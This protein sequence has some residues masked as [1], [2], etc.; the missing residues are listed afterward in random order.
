M[1]SKGT[2]SIEGC[3]SPAHCRGWCRS[4]YMRWYRY[5]D[6]HLKG[7]TSE[8][9]FWRNVAVTPSCWLWTGYIADTGYGQFASG[10]TR[11]AHRIS[12]QLVV[13]PIPEGLQIDHLCRVRHCVNPLHLEPV[14]QRENLLRGETI[15][16]RNAAKTHCPR[17]HAYTA[18]NT[19]VR[20][21]GSR[22]C[23][24]CNR[25]RQAK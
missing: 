17:G 13:G 6:P 11:L 19:Y 22:E 14:T 7:P 10:H 15:T 4:H 21:R 20:P 9:L 23:R 16:A 3:E 24:T 18:E 1:A 25:L 2:C 5:G 12:Y 8:D